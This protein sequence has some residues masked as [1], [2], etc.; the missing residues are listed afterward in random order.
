MATLTQLRRTL[1][2]AGEPH[3][4]LPLQDGAVAL[5]TR[6]G[7][8][9]LGLFPTPDADNLYWTNDA[10]R[11]AD[12]LRKF[13]SGGEWNLGG[14]RFWIAP[15]V[16]FN[17]RNRADFFGTLIVPPTVD[18][19]DYAMVVDGSTVTFHEELKLNAYNTGTGV[20]QLDIRRSI[21]PITNP[22]RGLRNYTELMRGV[23]Y[24]GYEQS[25]TLTELDNTPLMSE[26]WNLV[27]LNAGGQLIIPCSA[28]IEAS[29]YFGS[30][31]EE[32]RAVVNNHLRLRITGKRQYKVG[33]KAASMTGRMG[34]WNT[35]PNGRE[36]IIVR[37]FFNNPSSIYAE[38]PPDKPGETGHSVHVY[39]D[40]G[41]F[42]GENSFGEM[43]C[44]GQTIGG[45]TGR[46]VSTDNF[47]LWA[48]I[49]APEAI[50]RIA[51]I[52]IGVSL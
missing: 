46:Q 49:G 36:Y 18:P 33:Y 23:N 37:Q 27:Q 19:G 10:L 5:I 32:A 3:H 35:L 30:V 17:V 22:L 9:V 50:R 28:E 51:R 34:Y 39:N 20:K 29:D 41:Q 11:S 6:R 4:I 15:E 12:T 31:P 42:G 14:E 8:R 40:G 13:V 21:Q 7:A 47:L 26:V 44:S 48:Y 43:E 16:Q 2:G 52:L 1:D 25:A 45:R 38:E 24:A